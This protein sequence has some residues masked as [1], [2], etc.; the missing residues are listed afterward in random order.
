L[1]SIN[2]RSIALM[3][4]IFTFFNSSCIF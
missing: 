3:I 1:V 4:G 2:G